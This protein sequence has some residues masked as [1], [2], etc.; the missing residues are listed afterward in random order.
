MK[1][2]T[3]LLI[4]AIVSLVAL[5][6]LPLVSIGGYGASLFDALKGGT[7]IDI[8]TIITLVGGAVLIV[9]SIIK[10]KL[11]S[12]LGSA[13]ALGCLAYSLISTLDAAGSAGL[14]IIGIGFWIAIVGYLVSLVLSITAD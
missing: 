1:K 4:V 12:I 14:Q 13:A 11:L 9:G 5:L 6:F 8:Y 2:Y 7:G 10:N 3:L